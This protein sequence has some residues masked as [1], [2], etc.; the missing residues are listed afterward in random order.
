[1][2]LFYIDESGDTS[3]ISQKGT[4]YLVLSGCAI[5]ESDIQLIEKDWR[6]LKEKYF[7][8]PDIEIKSNFLRY[9]N[10]DVPQSSPLKL[11]LRSKYNE[12]EAEVTSFLQSIPTILFSVVINKEQFWQRQPSQNPYEQAYILLLEQFHEFLRINDSLGICII[13]PRE[14]QVEKHFFGNELGRIHTKLR[15]E[16]GNIWGK[17][18]RVVEKLLFSQSDTTI[19]I[20]FA[21]LYCYPIFHIFEYNKKFGDYWR[22]DEVSHS[23]FFSY[24]GDISL[25]TYPLKE[26]K[27]MKKD[28]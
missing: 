10:P 14:G 9:A 26:V 11:N 27:S 7:Q 1:M 16:D 17:C 2:Y 28:L 6:L 8:N 19:G 24:E 3:P 15:W 12:L 21:D 23:K 18:E 4:Q 20:Q 25:T 5:H 13:D 22:F